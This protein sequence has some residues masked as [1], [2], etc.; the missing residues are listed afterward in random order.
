MGEQE[1]HN[2][3]S[4]TA[5]AKRVGC[6]TQT[7][8]FHS[9]EEA[10]EIAWV[11]RNC[12]T[13]DLTMCTPIAWG[14]LRKQTLPGI[15][16]DVSR[17]HAPPAS[18]LLFPRAGSYVSARKKVEH[19]SEEGAIR[20]SSGRRNH[21]R[22]SQAIGVSKTVALTRGKTCERPNFDFSHFQFFSCGLCPAE[23]T[24]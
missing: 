22:A 19:V 21:G 6:A 16:S 15:P 11:S 4:D 10:L 13:H 12:T 3:R 23:A 14:V 18:G 20:R 9:I 24:G 8:F 5:R 17:G 7:N 2:T 1:L